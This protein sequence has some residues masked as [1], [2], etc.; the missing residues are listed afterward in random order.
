MT[1]AL[2][3]PALDPASLPLRTGSS[4]PEPFTAPCAKREKRVLGDAL[5][6]NS[7]GVN[8]TR[9][10]PGDWSA[11][12]H[13]HS[14]E[15]EFVYILEG[16]ATLVTDAG[17]QQ[18]GPGMVAGFPAGQAD[19]HHLVNRGDVPVLYLEVGDR[20][21]DDACHYPDV[22]LFLEPRPEGHRFTNKQGEPY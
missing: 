19:G 15:D 13:W 12:R 10:N 7:F 1:Q 17:E 22:D 11:Q 6:L 2:R 21:A 20:R 3:L 4:Y 8:L 18:L 14:A 16:E 5:G 9:L